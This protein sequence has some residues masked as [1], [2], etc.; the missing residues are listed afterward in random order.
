MDT[1]AALTLARALLR[2]HGLPDWTVVLTRAKRQAGV[3]RY[4][5]R[6][7]GLSGPLTQLH[8]EAEVRD[9][10]LHEIAHALAGPQHGH[11]RVWRATALA[12]GCTG[13]R[14]SS[15]EAAQLPTAWVGTCPRGHTVG[16]HRRPVRVASCRQ[17]RPGFSLDAVFEWAYHG[18][19]APM[20]PNYTAELAALRQGG[21]LPGLLR[22]GQQ[23]RITVPGPVHGTLG[24]VVKRGRTSYH[25]RVG[26]LT[27]RVAFAGVEP[28]PAQPR[29][30]VGR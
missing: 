5:T 9:T 24:Q 8:D 7:I 30:T 22:P 4:A 18:R 16:R 10:I 29:R 1:T 11:D 6:Q 17:C 28:V 25:V 2:E 21:G 15:P 19:A 13:Q 26:S 23:V 14:C 27:Y 20:H 12:I 3:C